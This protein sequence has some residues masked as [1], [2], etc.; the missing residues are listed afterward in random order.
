MLAIPWLLPSRSSLLNGGLVALGALML[1][2]GPLL[3]WAGR[4]GRLVAASAC[5]LNWAVG[6]VFSVLILASASYLAEAFG[7][8]GSTVAGL[9]LV[10]VAL[11]VVLF[12]LLPL[13]ELHALRKSGASR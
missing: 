3:I 9:S 1:I 2:S 13:H 5:L 8:M 12:W 10:L 4:L 7:R 6:T 11:T